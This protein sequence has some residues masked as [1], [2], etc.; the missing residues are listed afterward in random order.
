MRVARRAAF[1]A[2]GGVRLVVEADDAAPLWP[3]RFDPLNV[4]QVNG[5]LLHTRF[6]VLGNDAGTVELI[7]EESADIEAVTVAVG[8]HPLFSG[9]HQ[10]S[11]VGFGPPEVR[12]QGDNVTMVAK[13]LKLSL[14]GA[15]IRRSGDTLFVSLP[16][17]RKGSEA[18][19]E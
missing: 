7:D 11:V 14:R 9:V 17:Q 15:V 19:R 8:A 18:S 3:Q 4:E 13:G 2:R 5:G 10:L 16:R 1:D 12:E 6:L